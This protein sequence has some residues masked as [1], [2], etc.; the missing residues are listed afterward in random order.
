MSAIPPTLFW[1]VLLVFG[2]YNFLGA[3]I[4]I[5][6]MSEML[7]VTPKMYWAMIFPMGLLGVY[8][9]GMLTWFGI[10][11]IIWEIKYND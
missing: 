2:A 8:I 1:A 3:A 6:I 9:F 7:T 5:G 11:D 4:G 10:N